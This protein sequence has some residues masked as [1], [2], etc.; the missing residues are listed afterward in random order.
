MAQ[1]H[2][3][4][5]KWAMSNASGHRLRA[6]MHAYE[7]TCSRQLR[8]VSTDTCWSAGLVEGQGFG[9]GRDGAAYSNPGH[10]S[11]DDD[12]PDSVDDMLFRVVS[13]EDERRR[14]KHGQFCM[15]QRARGSEPAATPP[16]ASL[17]AAMQ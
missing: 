13:G 12:V 5:R 7:S 9:E 10:D 4:G 11:L 2:W 6:A 15:W 8:I 1:A 3:R 16:V 14:K 17:G